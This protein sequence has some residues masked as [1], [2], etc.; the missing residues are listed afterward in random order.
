MV[1]TQ[2][3]VAG[4]AAATAT[5]IPVTVYNLAQ[6]KFKGIPYLTKKASRRR[7]PLHPQ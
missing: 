2:M 7:R 1:S 6:A 4:T 5:A 3:P